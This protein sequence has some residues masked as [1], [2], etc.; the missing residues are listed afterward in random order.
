MAV[1]PER[2]LAATSEI[3]PIIQENIQ[4]VEA[5]IAATHTPPSPGSP[6]PMM[7]ETKGK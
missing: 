6:P 3:L 2:K 4:K 1:E 5:K 7:P